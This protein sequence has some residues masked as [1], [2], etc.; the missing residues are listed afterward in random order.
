MML[1]AGLL[2]LGVI[3]Q[4]KP[5]VYIEPPPRV[6]PTEAEIQR[7]IANNRPPLT[8]CYER[9]RS[10]DDTVVGGT[11]IVTLSIGRSGFVEKVKVATATPSLRAVEPCFQAVISRWAFPRSPRNY[12]TQFPAAFESEC[13]MTVRSDPWSEVWLDGKDTERHTPFVDDRIACGP[14]TLTLKRPD[15]QIEKTESITLL[16]GRRFEKSYTL[17][18]ER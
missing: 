16:A 1:T 8:T 10:K 18:N 12:Q 6:P 11:V 4:A 14:H 9:A 13:T 3:A 17:H 7:V 5:G 2:I 15:L